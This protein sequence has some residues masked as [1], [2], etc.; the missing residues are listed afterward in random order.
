[1]S[2][3]GSIVSVS[4]FDDGHQDKASY[5]NQWRVVAVMFGG[6]KLSLVNCSNLSAVISSISAWKTVPVRN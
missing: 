3:V 2:F 6:G 4:T 1:M 5:P